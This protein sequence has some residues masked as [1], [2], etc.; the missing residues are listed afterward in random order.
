MEVIRDEDDL[1]ERG[2]VDDI[3][4]ILD[5]AAVWV[6]VCLRRRSAV[7]E[8]WRIEAAKGGEVAAAEAEKLM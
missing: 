7:F 1:S 2:I 5:E 3:F 8:K 4:R 6:G